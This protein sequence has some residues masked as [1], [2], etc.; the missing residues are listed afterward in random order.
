LFKSQSR[1][2]NRFFLLLAFLQFR[3]SWYLQRA[4]EIPTSSHNSVNFD[5]SGK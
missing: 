5:R 4:A 2:L 1:G 3:S